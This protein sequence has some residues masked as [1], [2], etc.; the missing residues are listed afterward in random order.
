[1]V[2]AGPV[3]AAPRQTAGRHEK[4]KPRATESGAT[5][6]GGSGPPQAPSEDSDPSPLP[7]FSPDLMSPYF[8]SL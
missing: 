2:F 6:T 5:H 1:M 7:P 4:L 3:L 8:S